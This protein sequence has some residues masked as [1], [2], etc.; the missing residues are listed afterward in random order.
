MRRSYGF[1]VAESNRASGQF[2][3]VEPDIMLTQEDAEEAATQMREVAAIHGRGE[4]Y[5][6]VELLGVDD[7]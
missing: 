7:D 3:Y 5:V 4:S 1:S 6:V 2:E